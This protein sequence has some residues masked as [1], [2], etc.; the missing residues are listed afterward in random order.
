[1]DSLKGPILSE[2]DFSFQ[3]VEEVKQPKS[4]SPKE[5]GH[6]LAGL[7]DETADSIK[8]ITSEIVMEAV[9]EYITEN[10]KKAGAE[11]E[12]VTHTS[13]AINTQP[14][15][16]YSATTAAIKD[17]KTDSSEEEFVSHHKENTKVS[18]LK[19]VEQSD[20]QNQIIIYYNRKEAKQPL[21]EKE[22]T[23]TS[24]YD[25]SPLQNKES[26][27]QTSTTAFQKC[28]KQDHSIFLTQCTRK[29]EKLP[30]NMKTVYKVPEMDII[31]ND[32]ENDSEKDEY[33]FRE[34]LNK[35]YM[36][37]YINKDMQRC[38]ECIKAS[39][40]KVIK[41]PIPGQ[42][43]YITK[44]LTHEDDSELVGHKTGRL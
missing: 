44:V 16:E 26:I 32:P 5:A 19:F 43:S 11:E 34:K 28:L 25:V 20:K 14:S 27:H 41:E 38:I 35:E 33:E 30:K 24:G 8:L 13:G 31:K 6:N 29:Q 15:S 21:K 7:Q 23:M 42:V 10:I 36:K 17:I 4:I 3:H 39:D 18:G 40:L 1:M 22:K 2:A 37:K 9:S 12:K